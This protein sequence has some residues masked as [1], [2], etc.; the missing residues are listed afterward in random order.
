M[1]RHVAPAAVALIGLAAAA[2]LA[3]RTAAGGQ[4]EAVQPFNGRNLTGRQA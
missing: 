3:T 1:R 2:A 4:A